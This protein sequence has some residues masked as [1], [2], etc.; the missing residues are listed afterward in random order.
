MLMNGL[1]SGGIT[2]LLEPVSFLRCG[3]MTNSAALRHLP[4]AV[5]SFAVVAA[6]IRKF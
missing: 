6:G 3:C 5:E 2:E 1:V 4:K